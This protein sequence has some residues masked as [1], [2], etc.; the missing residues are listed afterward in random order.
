MK[1]V[2]ECLREFLAYFNALEKYGEF[3]YLLCG[4]IKR[5]AI[6]IRT[7]LH[8]IFVYFH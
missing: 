7:G 6:E 2:V 4:V 5:D 3:S 1:N 8:I